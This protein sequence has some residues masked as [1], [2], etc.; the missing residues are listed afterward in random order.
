MSK[1]QVHV[2]ETLKNIY[3][4]LENPASYS[5]AQKLYEACDRKISKVEIKEW[6]SGQNAYTLHKPIRKKY[7]RNPYIVNGINSQVQAD[8]IDMGSLSDKNDGVKFILLTIDSFSRFVNVRPLRSKSALEVLEALKSIFDTLDQSP[9]QMITDRGKEFF[10]KHMES[11]LKSIRTRHFA[12]SDDTFKAAIA[13][14]AIRTFK[15]IL[16]KML[17]GTL[18]L[19]YIDIL[20]KVAATMNSRYHRSINM[21]PIDVNQT[22]VNKV[23]LF[24]YNERQKHLNKGSK[25]I[26]NVGDSVRI[27]KNKSSQFDK[28]FLPNYTDEIFKINVRILRRPQP[29]YRLI[30]IN[31]KELESVF[32][33]PELQRVKPSE[34][35]IFR[36]EKILQRKKIR[37]VKHVRVSWKGFDK[38]HNSWIRESDLI[39]NESEG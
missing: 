37:G 27:A 39:D 11:Y 26:L 7:L 36:I 38:S 34:E 32:Y 30:D 35:T 9:Y 22:N 18:K 20:Q 21:A 6:L 5:T 33:G 4:N 25:N 29:V 12:P 13:E 19:R 31:N 8:L 23:W 1:D 16:Y 2:D 3:Y 24:M 15:G 14:R 28:G 10:N 17:T